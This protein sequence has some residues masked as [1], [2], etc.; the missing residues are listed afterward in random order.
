MLKNVCWEKLEDKDSGYKFSFF[1]SSFSL[2]VVVQNVTIFL[3]QRSV[4]MINVAVLFYNLDGD[5]SDIDLI[6]GRKN[7][8][9]VNYVKSF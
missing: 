9:I 1:L 6:S 7:K 5:I 2:P 3:K 8:Y 4:F